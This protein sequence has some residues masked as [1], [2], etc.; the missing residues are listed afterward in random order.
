M[1]GSALCF[2]KTALATV[3][4]LRILDLGVLDPSEPAGLLMRPSKWKGVLT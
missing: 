3:H 4:N 1:T 2:E